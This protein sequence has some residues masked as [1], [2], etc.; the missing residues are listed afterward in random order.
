MLR[1]AEADSVPGRVN[2]CLDCD[3]SDK[4][5]EADTLLTVLDVV[6]KPAY[7]ERH[8]LEAIPKN[9]KA[10]LEYHL[11]CVEEIRGQGPSWSC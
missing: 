4:L 9:P 5:T 3:D 2:F 11:Y 6:N 1:L 10:P 7:R 8:G